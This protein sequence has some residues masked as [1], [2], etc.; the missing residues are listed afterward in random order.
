MD[1]EKGGANGMIKL[2]KQLCL[3][4]GTSGREERVRAF[5]LQRLE[6]KNL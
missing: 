3:L 1:F 4:N 5:I 6:K 2:L